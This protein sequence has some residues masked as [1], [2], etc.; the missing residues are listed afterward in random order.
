MK[1]AALVVLMLLLV[2]LSCNAQATGDAGAWSFGLGV[3]GFDPVDGTGQLKNQSGQYALTLDA[4]FRYTEY[5]SFGF[6]IFANEQRFDTPSAITAPLFGTV[7]GRSRIS[8]GG[9]NAVAKLGLPLGR[10]EPYVGAAVG[11][12]FNSMVVTGSIFGLPARAEEQDSGL[13]EQLL[14]GFNYRVADSWSLG[15]EYRH[16]YLKADF[17]QLTGGEVDVGGDSIMATVRFGSPSQA[18]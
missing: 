18:R 14:A 16:T 11:L 1:D 10:L 8:G 9:L 3:G 12:Y 15:V 7:D 2:P 4:T 17:G 5:V 13:G 6:D